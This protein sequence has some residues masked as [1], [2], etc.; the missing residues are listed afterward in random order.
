M[1]PAILSTETN[2][3]M[4]DPPPIQ[5]RPVAAGWTYPLQYSMR[6]RKVSETVIVGNDLE[7]NAYIAGLDLDYDGDGVTAIM[8]FLVQRLNTGS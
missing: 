4:Q 3:F 7:V 8:Y 1:Q 2:L 5:D 6:C